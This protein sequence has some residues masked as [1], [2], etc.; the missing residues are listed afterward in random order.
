MHWRLD[1]LQENIPTSL[2]LKELFRRVNTHETAFK[3]MKDQH[4]RK[5]TVW[6]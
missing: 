3:R 1:S 2:I 4:T 6:W 5:N